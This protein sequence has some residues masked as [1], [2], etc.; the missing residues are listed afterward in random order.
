[1]VAVCFREKGYL[2][3]DEMSA[4]VFRERTREKSN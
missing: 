2:V 3:V 4:Y 1:M